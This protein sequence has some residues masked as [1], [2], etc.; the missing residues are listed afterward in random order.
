M[1]D[2][3]Y[4]V[5]CGFFD[6][7]N[8]D[9]EYSAEQMNRPYKR[10][11]NNG[12]FATPQGTPSTDLQVFS[13]NNGMNVI[14][15]TG[16]GLFGDKWFENP[17]DLIITISTNSDIVPRIDSI[18]AQVDNTQ[19]GRVGNI[20]YRKGTP[21]SSPQPPTM[22]TSENI[23][24]YRLANII[25][26][27]STQNIT[28][29]LITDTR[30]S[31]ECPWIT[32]LIQQV[33]TSTLYKQ[34][35]EAYQKY[36]DD[37][38]QAFNAFMKDL[39]EQLNVNTNLVKYESHFVTSADNTT[40]IPINISTF[41]KNKDILM[42]KINNLFVSE[43]VDYTISE[44]SNNI[45]L[46][47]PIKSG[48]CVDFLVLQS[49]IIGD[50]ETLL[51]QVQKLQNLVDKTKI[52]DN[53]GGVEAQVTDSNNVLDVFK[54]LGIGF[55]TLYAY[56]NITGIPV[57]GTYYLFG[58]LI[59]ENNGW[60][61]ALKSDRSMYENQIENGNW[62]GWKSLFEQSPVILYYNENGKLP[63]DQQEIIPKKKL[64]DC[65][66]G[67]Q[68][69]FTGYNDTNNTANDQY[70]QIVNI[71]KYSYKNSDWNGEDVIFD[72]IYGYASSGENINHCIKS[73]SVYDNRI[74]SNSINITGNSKKMVLRAIYEY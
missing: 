34:W 74:I 16:E 21:S 53:N 8:K 52:T 39:T 27:P 45:T 42:V 23:F 41:N 5:S 24:E 59:N 15:K 44:D 26:N 35:Q 72:L 18:I 62:K 65:S 68:L 3:K 56:D 57:E 14:V 54:G 48:Q 1:D 30:G 55:H 17:S 58:H 28:Q 13:A 32:S 40:V 9:R 10:V 47:N 67:W 19:S 11:I 64:S 63:S 25:I 29:N 4:A 37:E 2:T 38:T 49:V 12:V 50:T 73:F 69:I 20:V 66:H 31:D 43:T 7:I 6:S 22:N 51:Q 70:A 71:P 33:D 46:I 60:I 61:I 36:Y